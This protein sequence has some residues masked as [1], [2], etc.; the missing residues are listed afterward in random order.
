LMSVQDNPL[1]TDAFDLS[2]TT[3]HARKNGL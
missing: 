2:Y 1:R 3:P